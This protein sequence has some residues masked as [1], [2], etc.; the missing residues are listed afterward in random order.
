MNFISP[1]PVTA[2][3]QDISRLARE[4]FFHDPGKARERIFQLEILLRENI[5]EG[6]L[7]E[8]T[9]DMP[10]VH[11]FIPGAYGRELHIPAGTIL[12]G[13]I[14]RAPCFNFVNAGTITVLT[15]DGIKTITAPA[16]FRSDAG[17]KRV[18]VAHTDTVWITMHPT[19]ETDLERLEAE[20]TAPDFESIG[21]ID[22]TV[23][24]ETA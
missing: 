16:F 18:G 3:A 23:I 4:L 13:K 12:V 22:G 14:H 1:E 20:I 2:G 11:H 21:Q 19:N 6:A 24:K 5:K 17:V 15:E 7:V 10:L 9:H 8:N